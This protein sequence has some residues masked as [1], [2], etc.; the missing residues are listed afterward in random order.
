MTSR[1]S[2]LDNQRE[3]GFNGAKQTNLQNFNKHELE[4]ENGYKFVASLSSYVP[5]L[6]RYYNEISILLA[7]QK[8]INKKILM[9]Q[10]C[11]LKMILNLSH[12]E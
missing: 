6:K 4:K 2:N 7:L 9:C 5:V 1:Q 3:F 12:D 11:Y 8:S 10:S